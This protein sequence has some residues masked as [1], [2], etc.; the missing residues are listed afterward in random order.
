[1]HQVEEG[2]SGQRRSKLPPTAAR[3]E[4]GAEKWNLSQM[5]HA[6]VCSCTANRL[7]ALC[8]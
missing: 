4:T 5:C 2:S 8:P 7:K 6:L 3:V 1:M